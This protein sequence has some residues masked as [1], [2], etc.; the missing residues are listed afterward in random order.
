[1]M[2]E[3][4]RWIEEAREIPAPKDY[5]SPPDPLA[6]LEARLRGE[7]APEAGE[8]SPGRASQAAVTGG[9]SG[10]RSGD[11]AA[12]TGFVGG[13]G[14]QVLGQML[15]RT[16]SRRPLPGALRAQVAARLAQVIAGGG[17]AELEQIWELVVF[18]DGD[19]DQAGGA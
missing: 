13:S 14:D 4:Q 6:A 2:E 1:M 19:G 7:E 18:G 8:E 17:P 10:A 5:I 16:L 9:T 12:G 3:L 15:T 11:S